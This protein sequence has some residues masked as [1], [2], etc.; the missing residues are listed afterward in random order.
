MRFGDRREVETPEGESYYISMTDMMVGVVFIFILLLSF[1]ALQLRA[2]TSA[3]TQASDPKT[4]ALLQMATN[5]E[6]KTV[7][8]QIDYDNKVLC[9]PTTALSKEAPSDATSTEKRC[10]AYSAV[11][12]TAPTASGPSSDESRSALTT[13]LNGDLAA[14]TPVQ[15]DAASG[16]LTFTADDLFIPGSDALSPKGVSTT[17]DVAKALAGRLPCYGFGPAADASCAATA[18]MAAVNVAGNASFNAFSTEGQAAYDLALRRTVAFYK[19][20]I[21]NQPVLGQIKDGP[22][23]DAQPLLRVASGG[24]S[25]A[26]T[27]SN[28]AEQSI[29]IQ[30]VMQ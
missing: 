4:T 10:F 20:L 28:T 24:Q 5:L 27:A 1:F 22:T 9:V 7:A 15:A 2:T 30:F 6:D 14:K 3:L 17:A 8:L 23:D 16:T 29:S 12:K 25:K 11:A 21:S 18:K 26:A 19:A 13:F